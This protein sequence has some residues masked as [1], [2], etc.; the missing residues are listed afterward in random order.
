KQ[1]LDNH[2]PSA[3]QSD[4]RRFE[5]YYWWRAARLEAAAVHNPAK[6]KGSFLSL[7]KLAVSP[8][9]ELVAVG[10][11]HPH[12][13]LFDSV[14]KKEVP[15]IR[16]RRDR[17]GVAPLAFARDGALLVVAGPDHILRRWQT[18]TWTSLPELTAHQ[19]G[20]GMAALAVSPSGPLLASA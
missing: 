13:L 5:W 19:K 2:R 6:E 15:R 11:S 18:R 1:V 3:G 14:H 8:D 16:I 4:L 9:G 10:G 20:R 7:Q 12:L 17:G